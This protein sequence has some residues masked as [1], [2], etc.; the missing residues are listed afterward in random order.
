VTRLGR[1]LAARCVLLGWLGVAATLLAFGGRLWWVLELFVHFRPWYVV[2]LLPSAACALWLGRRVSAGAMLACA[3]LNLVVV[4]PAWRGLLDRD[5]GS[6]QLRIVVFNL[7][8]RSGRTDEMV[9]FLAQLRADAAV[10]LEVGP[11]WREPLASLRSVYPHQLVHS[12]DDP[13]G[14]A[15]LSAH[16]C[17]PCDE[18]QEEGVPP[19]LLGRL[20]LGRGHLWIAGV[21]AV[22]PFNGEW[23][24]ERDGYLR[25][26][27]RRLAAL[28]GPRVLAGDFNTTPWTSGYRELLAADLHDGNRALASWPAFLPFPVVPIDHVLVSK[29][30]RVVSKRRG[31]PLGSDHYPIVVELAMNRN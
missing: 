17:A 9:R 12:R 7:S 26:M 22:P 2:L 21:H 1:A 6:A 10:L 3:L 18:I 24:R 20:A 16:P 5:G 25:G 31:L 8:I 28:A 11:Q 19:A 23:T 15:L 4:G 27:S 13:F 30:L 29:E 14:I